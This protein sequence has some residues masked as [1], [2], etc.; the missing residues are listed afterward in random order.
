MALLPPGKR[1]HSVHPGAAQEGSTDQR[2]VGRAPAAQQPPPTPPHPSASRQRGRGPA[3]SVAAGWPYLR[4]QL[5]VT[6]AAPEDL[7]PGAWT[8]CS[9]DPG[10]LWSHPLKPLFLGSQGPAAEGKGLRGWKACLCPTGLH[11]LWESSSVQTSSHFFTRF[12]GFGRFP[13]PGQAF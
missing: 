12:G 13:A 7:H 9:F 3:G 5:K 10:G 11:F 2:A 6:V 1:H 4:P 8:P